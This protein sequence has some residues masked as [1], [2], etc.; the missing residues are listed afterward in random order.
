MII[1][2]NRYTISNKYVKIKRAAFSTSPL[3]GYSIRHFYHLVLRQSFEKICHICCHTS[4]IVRSSLGR[5]ATYFASIYCSSTS[6]RDLRFAVL[7]GRTTRLVYSPV[8]EMS[9][10]IIH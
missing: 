6:Y 2:F 4:P 8:Y 9:T 5:A 3:M 7:S 1:I 10:R